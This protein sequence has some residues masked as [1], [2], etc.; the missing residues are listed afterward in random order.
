MQ[1]QLEPARL[2]HPAHELLEPGQHVLEAAQAV[3]VGGEEV[4][5]F[6][7]VLGAV[8]VGDEALEG[9]VDE[10]DGPNGLLV[11]LDLEV[12]VL[13]LALAAGATAWPEDC[14][15]VRVHEVVEAFGLAPLPRESP[16]RVF[17]GKNNDSTE[18]LQFLLLSPRFPRSLGLGSQFFHWQ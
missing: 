10:V 4:A 16:E 2:A 3:E 15:H 13:G 12:L 17:I 7:G 1:F 5:E 9:Q 18:V 6:V 11:V 8:D 14:L